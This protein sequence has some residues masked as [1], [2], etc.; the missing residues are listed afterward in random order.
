[1]EQEYHTRLNWM[2]RSQIESALESV[3]IA[4]YDSEST[5]DLRETLRENVLDGT[6][7]KNL[8]PEWR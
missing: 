7:D 1:M 3:G 8:L 2:G 6:Y 5:D 4:C